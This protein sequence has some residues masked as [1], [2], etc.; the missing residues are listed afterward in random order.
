MSSL[1][2]PV[3]VVTV[4]E[5]DALHELPHMAQVL[6]L[7]ALRPHMDVA[8]GLVGMVRRISERGLA[9][10]ATVPAV[11]G[12]G[13]AHVVTPT[14]KQVRAALTALEVAG[15]I[16]AVK[17]TDRCF[18][19]QL[20]LARQDSS[21]RRS[22]GQIKGQE[23]T[24]W[25]PS[26]DAGF[27]PAGD[28]SRVPS[29]GPHQGYITP[30]RSLASFEIS[31]G[32]R[33]TPD[34]IVLP[35]GTDLGVWQDFVNHWRQHGRWSVSRAKQCAGHLRLI[36]AEGGNP[37]EVLGWALA[38][39]LADLLDAHRRMRSDAARFARDDR[40]PGESQANRAARQLRDRF[41]SAARVI[42][43]GALLGSGS[44]G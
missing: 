32:A 21:V 10:V 11:A 2:D 38:R 34:A 6:Y 26:S 8:T 7:R 44:D 37:T 3:V 40:R 18:V 12:R 31:E 35:E 4:R 36:V 22:R 5:L 25:K 24:P 30:D 23:S 29:R 17:G 13:S 20:P 39:H 15:V 27:S 9:E 28:G 41:G 42:D 33:A 43:G 16:R 1:P 19:F 14:R